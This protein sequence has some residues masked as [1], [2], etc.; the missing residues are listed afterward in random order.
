M[1]DPAGNPVPG[2]S[3]FIG[4][5]EARVTPAGVTA[6]RTGSASVNM[7]PGSY[8]VTLQAPG[9]GSRTVT[10]VTVAAGTV[11]SRT[12]AISQNLASASNGA[13]VAA[14]SGDD[15]V[16]HATSL[17]DDTEATA[18]GNTKSATAADQSG[19]VTVALSPALDT[20]G[21]LVSAIRLGAFTGVGLPRFGAARDYTIEVSDDGTAWTAV[22]TGTVTTAPPRPVAPELN[23]QTITLATP[24]HANF[25]RLDVSHTQGPATELSVGELQVF[26]AAP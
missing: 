15:G 11:T 10:G 13:T 18:W 22:S 8:D 21:T 16:N 3:V 7:V 19:S 14:A 20:P 24:V 1:T 9:W 17:I 23:Y 4:D 6:S 26:A 2:V 12:V 25:V 5:Y